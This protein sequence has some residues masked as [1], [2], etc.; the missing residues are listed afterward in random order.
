MSL[1]W[2]LTVDF[3]WA[4]LSLFPEGITILVTIVHPRIGSDI[5]IE[6]GWNVAAALTIF[7]T[8]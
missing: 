4:D 8:D 5:G 3:E 6:H 1:A 7:E 2:L